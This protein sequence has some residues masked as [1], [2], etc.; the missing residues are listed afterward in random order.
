MALQDFIRKYNYITDYF[1]YNYNMYINTFPAFAVNYYS[2]NVPN[3]DV[4]DTFDDISGS[5]IWEDDQL[6]G[7]SYEKLGIGELSGVT[8]KKI[9]MLPVF[10]TTHVNPSQ[11]SDERGVTYHDSMIS[12]ITI[13][14]QYGLNPVSG[15]CVDLSFGLKEKNITNKTIFVITGVKLATH[16]EEYNLYQLDLKVAPFS[17]DDID[18]QCDKFFR[19]FEPSKAILPVSNVNILNKLLQR[20]DES[21][22]LLNSDFKDNINLFITG[23]TL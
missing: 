12:Q 17:K 10:N 23:N 15:D 2:L 3:K 16:S 1:D 13:P 18:N 14:E 11:N 9:F 6:K 4:F 19:F 20:T 7:G 8:W 21:V 22:S 5:T